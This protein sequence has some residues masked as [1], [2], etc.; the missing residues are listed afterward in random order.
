M[1][2]RYF[3]PFNPRSATLKASPD[4]SGG[5]SHV[6][7]ELCDVLVLI[8]DLVLRSSSSN[9]TH[10]CDGRARHRPKRHVALGPSSDVQ[11]DADQID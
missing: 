8:G 2:P 3:I 11:F 9:D 1:R 6:I 7:E 5:P 10:R 4:G